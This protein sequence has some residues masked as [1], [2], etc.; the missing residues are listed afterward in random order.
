MQENLLEIW[1]E[2]K[3]TV[4]FVTHDIEE[5]VYLADRVVV[6]SAS[7]GRLIADIKVNLP[8]PRPTDVFMD[9]HFIE[10]KAQCLQL[11][12]EE[13]TRAFEQQNKTA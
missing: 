10:V 6:M 13:T 9:P 5:A 4:L 1:K 8:R 12:R 7:P 2:F 3:N 11:I